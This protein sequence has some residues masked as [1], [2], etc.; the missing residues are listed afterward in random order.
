MSLINRSKQVILEHQH[1]SGAF[2]ASPAFDHYRYSWLRD[3]TFIAYSLDCVGE[4]EAAERFFSWAAGTIEAHR[5]KAS[6]II[7]RTRRGEEIPQHLLLHT[8][9]TVDG[10]EV[11]GEWGTYQLD[12]Y[13][14]WLWGMSEHLKN[15]GNEDFARKVKPTLTLI[16]EYL[17]PLWR[18]PNF[19]CWEEYGDL[20]HPSTVAAIYGGL[21]S[22]RPWVDEPLRQSIESELSVI[23][24]YLLSMGTQDG[25]FIKSI[26][27]QDVDASLLWL[28]VPFSVVE[29][30]HPVMVATV[31]EIE[32]TLL[33]QN[34][35]HRYAHDV[36][37]GGGQWVFLSAWLGWHYAETGNLNRSVELLKW[38]E[39]Q[40][41]NEGHLPEQVHHHMLAPEHFSRWVE[42]WGAPACP[43]L[44]SHA[45]HLILASKVEFPQKKD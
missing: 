26:G 32:E 9:Y 3:G 2:V 7:E 43:L 31:K 39:G 6:D 16:A 27:S 12:G 14:T 44:W 45:L 8:R 5:H 37:Y 30:G 25:R 35:V 15:S 24:H 36:Y 28:H 38:V 29:G 4:T 21:K 33:H 40:F 34:G 42:Q 11:Q 23:K 10:Q 41:N 19:D 17:L 1:T 13:G 22:I 18:M 20:V